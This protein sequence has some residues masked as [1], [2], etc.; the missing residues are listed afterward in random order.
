MGEKADLLL[1][2]LYPNIPGTSGR[3]NQVSLMDYMGQSIRDYASLIDVYAVLLFYSY[4]VGIL[5]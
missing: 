1:L 5:V 3:N 4:S 2:F